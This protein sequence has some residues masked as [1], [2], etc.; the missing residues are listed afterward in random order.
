M[1]TAGFPGFSCVPTSI[2]PFYSVL[3]PEG[4]GDLLGNQKQDQTGTTVSSEQFL[5]ALKLL[6]SQNNIVKPVLAL[7]NVGEEACSAALTAFHR[8]STRC[9]RSARQYPH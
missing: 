6:P 7:I 2:P 1:E 9:S 5:N 8:V 3:P 4:R